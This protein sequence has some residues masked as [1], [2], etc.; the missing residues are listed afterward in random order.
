MSALALLRCSS[1]EQAEGPQWTDRRMARRS[2]GLLHIDPFRQGQRIVQVDPKI[3]NSAVHLGMPEQKLNS[4]QVACLL[5]NLGN[6]R[7]SH[8]MGAIGARF[9]PDRENP[10]AHDPRILACR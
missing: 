7:A 3:A 10:V 1:G 2:S 5:V 9:K 8:R 6:L 4:A